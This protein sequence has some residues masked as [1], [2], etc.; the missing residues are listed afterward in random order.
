MCWKF[1]YSVSQI[2][3]SE[4]DLSSPAP[5][6]GDRLESERGRWQRSASCTLFSLLPVCERLTDSLDAF[7]SLTQVLENSP[8][9]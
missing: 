4:I 6:A 9:W 2:P 7:A 3:H 1:A 5:G 8:V